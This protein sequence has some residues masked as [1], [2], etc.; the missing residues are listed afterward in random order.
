MVI[1]MIKYLKFYIL[2]GYV[3]LVNLDKYIFVL[4]TGIKNN[5]I[6]NT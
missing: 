1:A 4:F 5:Y 3:L 2:Y 6:T